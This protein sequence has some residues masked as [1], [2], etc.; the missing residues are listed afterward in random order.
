M[1]YYHH[2]HYNEKKYKKKR[3]VK[4]KISDVECGY[5]PMPKK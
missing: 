3:E 5:S 4:P 1:Q 2:H